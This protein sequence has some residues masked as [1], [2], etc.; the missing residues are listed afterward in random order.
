MRK[1]VEADPVGTRRVLELCKD[2]TYDDD[3]EV[4]SAYTL[5]Y[6]HHD[7]YPYVSVLFSDP[8]PQT[9]AYA[10]SV[11]GHLRDKRYLPH[12]ERL[13]KDETRLPEGWFEKTVAERAKHASGWI[14]NEL[15]VSE[16]LKRVVE[17]LTADPEHP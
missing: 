1:M 15:P 11:A 16:E 2:G 3:I 17:N 8:S 10:A 9:R 6:A 14:R 7:V 5:M 4:I 13:A 12:L